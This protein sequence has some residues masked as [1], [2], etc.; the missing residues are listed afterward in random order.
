MPTYT[1]DRT[2]TNAPASVLDHLAQVYWHVG[3]AAKAQIE[4]AVVNIQVTV[5]ATISPALKDHF[6]VKEVP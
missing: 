6:A 4:T 2:A 5:A 1:L 3:P